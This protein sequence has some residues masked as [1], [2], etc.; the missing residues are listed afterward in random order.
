MIYR[1]INLSEEYPMLEKGKEEIFLEAICREKKPMIGDKKYPA[2]LIL[3][4]GG[5]MGLSEREAEPIALAFA[6]KGI[7]CFVLYYSVYPSSYP[8]Q[9][10]E[11]AAAVDYIRKHSDEY[12]VM[13]DQIS[14][15]GFSAGGHL[16]GN[17]GIEWHKDFLC[18][19]L[20]TEKENLRPNGLVLC[21]GVLSAVENAH[22]DSIANLLGDKVGDFEL[23]KRI[24]F[25]KNVKKGLTPPAF[26]WHTQED[27]LVPVQNS[28][29]A[30]Q[31]MISEGIPV[32]LH[33]YPH[34]WH[35]LSTADVLTLEEEA[36]ARG[37]VLPEAP[38]NWI[39]QC[40][41]FLLGLV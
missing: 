19:K 39:D 21:Y 41:R 36:I 2:L 5:Y 9:L 23:R 8:T 1:K 37:V 30:A 32:E 3:P 12:S 17:Y 10:Q 6:A 13:P 20:K 38:K 18:E 4:G 16:A 33:I 15:I 26:I 29:Q 28:I 14:I 31:A 22:E 27:Q 7:Q 40:A 24:S 11:A 35:G 25:E 34:G